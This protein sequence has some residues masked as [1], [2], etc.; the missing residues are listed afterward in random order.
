M[1]GKKSSRTRSTWEID[2]SVSRDELERQLKDCIH[3]GRTACRITKPNRLVY[4]VF[5]TDT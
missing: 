5:G 4:R 3:S 1:W 2:V